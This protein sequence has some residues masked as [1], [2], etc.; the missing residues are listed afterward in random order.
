MPG[1]GWCYQERD[2]GKGFPA[3]AT[4]LAAQDGWDSGQGARGYL[5]S[6]AGVAVSYLYL[7]LDRGTALYRHLGYDPAWSA[8]SVGAVLHDLAFAHLANEGVASRL[9]FTEGDGQHKR[10]F[11]SGAIGCADVIVAPPTLKH[12]AVFSAYRLWTAAVD[13]VKTLRQ[14]FA[15][16]D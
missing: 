8:L 11:A 1:L 15:F 12:H 5:L 2:L 13:H 3:D 16:K 4:A 14:H 7:S 6:V 9:D 10:A